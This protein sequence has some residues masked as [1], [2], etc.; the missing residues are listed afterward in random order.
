MEKTIFP[1]EV[2]LD[3]SP[4]LKFCIRPH[5]MKPGQVMKFTHETYWRLSQDKKKIKRISLKEYR[6][7]KNLD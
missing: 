7:A 2:M 6:D 3:K 4:E 5:R 1:D